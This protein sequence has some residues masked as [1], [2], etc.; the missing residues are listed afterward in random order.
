MLGK[1]FAIIWADR[2]NPQRNR[3]ANQICDFTERNID[4]S[5]SDATWRRLGNTSGSK[6]KPAAEQTNN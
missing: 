1:E 3:F 4:L 6:Q 2:S 5:E